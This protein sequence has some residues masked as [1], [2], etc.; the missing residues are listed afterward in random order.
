MQRLRTRFPNR[1]HVVPSMLNIL[2][3]KEI[4]EV[5][6]DIPKE[7]MK[8][9]VEYHQSMFNVGKYL[10][11]NHVGKIDAR[12]VQKIRDEIRQNES[13]VKNI[14]NRLKLKE[15][16]LGCKD[17]PRTKK[18]DAVV[19]VVMDKKA[20]RMRLTPAEI[21]R[22][23]SVLKCDFCIPSMKKMNYLASFESEIKKGHMTRYTLKDYS[24]AMAL[25]AAKIVG[26]RSETISSVKIIEMVDNIIATVSTSAG[27]SFRA[28]FKLVKDIFRMTTTIITKASTME[29]YIKGE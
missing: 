7:Y 5:R 14:K 2:S 13:M 22:I 25:V 17:M 6:K 8:G 24:V 26:A 18:N 29:I 1:K 3:F 28:V 23:E 9:T 11:E 20:Y 4:V 21:C 15:K 27:M 10:I 19:V 16:V 12:S